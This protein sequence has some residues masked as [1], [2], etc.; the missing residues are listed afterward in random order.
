MPTTVGQEVTNIFNKRVLGATDFDT[1]LLTSLRLIDQETLESVFKEDGMLQWGLLSGTA[2]PDEVTFS[3]PMRFVTSIDDMAIGEFS[4][5]AGNNALATFT[6]QNTLAQLYEFGCKHVRFPT[7]MTVNVRTGEPEFESYEIGFGEQGDPDLVTDLGGGSIELVIDSLLDGPGIDLSGVSCLIYLKDP[8]SDDDSISL[9]TATSTY[10]AGKNRVTVPAGGLGQTTVST[11]VT[12]YQVTIAGIFGIRSPGRFTVPAA[13]EDKYI[14]LGTATGSGAGNPVITVDQTGVNDFTMTFGDLATTFAG[15]IGRSMWPGVFQGCVPSNGG[16]L[17][18][19]LT[20][21]AIHTS[22][23]YYTPSAAT[24]VL[25]LVNTTHYVYWDA[26][27]EVWASS[28]T[29]S[30][31][32]TQLTTGTQQNIPIAHV[33]V[34][35][36]VIVDVIDVRFGLG[37][38]GSTFSRDRWRVAPEATGGFYGSEFTSTYAALEY[39]KARVT[40]GDKRFL[41]REI[42]IIQEAPTK[43]IELG[44]AAHRGLTLSGTWERGAPPATYN[45]TWG[46]DGPLFEIEMSTNCEDVTFRNIAAEWNGAANASNNVC[47][48]TEAAGAGLVEGL[49]IESNYVNSS[50]AGFSNSYIRLLNAAAAH[51]VVIR[52]NTFMGNARDSGI[53]INNPAGV[54][55]DPDK[56]P[57]LIEDNYIEMDNTLALVFGA[58]DNG[59]IVLHA[60]VPGDI[61]NAIIRGNQIHTT[62]QAGINATDC[63]GVLIEGNTIVEVARVNGAGI[64][65]S[66]TKVASVRENF[67]NMTTNPDLSMFGVFADDDDIEIVNNEILLDDRGG[68]IGINAITTSGL[69]IADNICNLPGGVGVAS[70]DG[71]VFGCSNK[72][73]YSCVNN[74]VNNFYRGITFGDGTTVMK[75][76][77]LIEGNSVSEFTDFGIGCNEPAGSNNEVQQSVI[78]NSIYS[79]QAAPDGIWWHQDGGNQSRFISNVIYMTISTGYGIKIEAGPIGALIQGNDIQASLA[80]AGIFLDALAG[81]CDIVDNKIYCGPLGILIDSTTSVVEHCKVCCNEIHGLGTNTSLAIHVTGVN[82]VRYCQFNENNIDNYDAAIRIVGG[83]TQ[84]QFNGNYIDTVG[85]TYSAMNFGTVTDRVSVCHNTINDDGAQF[86][87]EFNAGTHD[88][89]VIVGN[90]IVSVDSC[91]YLNGVD[92]FVISANRCETTGVAANDHAIWLTNGGQYNVITG[93]VASATGGGGGNGI[94]TA[95]AGVVG[96]INGNRSNPAVAAGTYTAANNI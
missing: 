22:G 9:I 33:E 93:N 17:D 13:S 60:P 63:Q 36:G 30:D 89:G 74:Q 91:L 86:A 73:G 14:F 38:D 79:T 11:V 76:G 64:R 96:L 94:D 48:I 62:Y 8:E 46:F 58:D 7:R 20:S 71:I 29:L 4:V 47:F 61:I 77:C 25:P 92:R 5:A 66:A 83:S 23:K 78:G 81:V 59:G 82:G 45:I 84:S 39:Y 44:G 56:R 10:S 88:D 27:N 55:G 53:L 26:V 67:I 6:F 49:T 31:A 50:G 28:T 19:D 35:G 51:S 18:V 69:R 1:R 41:P 75:Q 57:V 95:T 42:Q 52:G 72:A 34:S 54:S 87:V 21:G 3:L 32:Y 40:V 85:N 2:N 70:N 16:V 90:N 37:F 24:V 43:T 68:N 15:I 12:D 80:T 65:L